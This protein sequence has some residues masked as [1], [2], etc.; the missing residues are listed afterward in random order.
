MLIVLEG[1]FGKPISIDPTLIKW[2]TVEND[3]NEVCTSNCSFY[4]RDSPAEIAEKVNDALKPNLRCPWRN[5][6]RR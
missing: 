1:R 3:Y 2:V 5:L 6:K 4:V